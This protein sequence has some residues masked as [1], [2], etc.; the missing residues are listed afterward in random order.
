MSISNRT[1]SKKKKKKKNNDPKV[2]LLLLKY[3]PALNNQNLEEAG[4]MYKAIEADRLTEMKITGSEWWQQNWVQQHELLM[5]LT[6]KK[7]PIFSIQTQ[8]NN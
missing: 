2:V 1:Y 6:D 5:F 7:I 8:F 4:H 3:C